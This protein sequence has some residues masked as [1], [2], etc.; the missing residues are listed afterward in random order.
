MYIIVLVCA[1]ADGFGSFNIFL[2]LSDYVN[3]LMVRDGQRQNPRIM[4]IIHVSENQINCT[5]NF[6]SY[7]SFISCDNKN[8]L[9][10]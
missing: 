8:F 7:T 5:L 2:F 3:R 9:S 6:G 1:A 4:N 10:K